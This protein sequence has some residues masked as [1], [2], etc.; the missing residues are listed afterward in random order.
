MCLHPFHFSYSREICVSFT[1]VLKDLMSRLGL[2][3]GSAISAG[4]QPVG[5]HCSLGGCS[6]ISWL[7][8][9]LRQNRSLA[10]F[11]TVLHLILAAGLPFWQASDLPLGLAVWLPMAGWLR[12]SGWGKRGS[13]SPL[14][15][16]W[17]LAESQL[18]HVVPWA[19]LV[20]APIY[21]S[22]SQEHE[23]FSSFVNF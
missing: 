21:L 13:V 2:A 3:D 1:C 22:R 14:S 8:Q 4:C 15:C 12:G 6:R 9:G 10:V 7:L 5:S 18:S 17:N 16:G 11:W 20:Q 19:N 23:F